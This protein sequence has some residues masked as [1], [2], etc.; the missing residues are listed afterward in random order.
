MTLTLTLNLPDAPALR[1]VSEADMRLELACALHAQGRI[2]KTAGAEMAGL[3]LFAFQD[4]LGE[5]EISTY[6]VN[7]LHDEVAALRPMFPA[8]TL[9]VSK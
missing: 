4:A 7:D 2:S 9:P 6:T 8:Q 3:D 5:R 1:H